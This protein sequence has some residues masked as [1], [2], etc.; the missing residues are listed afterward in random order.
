MKRILLFLFAFS[1]FSCSKEDL[2]SDFSE[3]S[4]DSKLKLSSIVNPGEIHNDYMDLVN[5]SFVA[6]ESI[7]TLDGKYNFYYDFIKE[8]TD[9]YAKIKSEDKLFF[10]ETFKENLNL[11]HYDN[12]VGIV[13]NEILI[14]NPVRETETTL[15]EVLITLRD[16]EIISENEFVKM[17]NLQYTLHKVYESTVSYD[18]FNV[19]IESL[20]EDVNNNEYLIL[21][22]VSSIASYSNEWWN[23]NLPEIYFPEPVGIINYPDNQY[24]TY[25]IPAVV[26]TDIAGAIVGA[27]GVALNQYINNNGKITGGAVVTGAVVGAV[28]GSTGLVGR[29]GKWISRL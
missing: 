23:S 20:S 16:E 1:I 15:S 13:K 25:A 4:D 24:T 28:V 8:Y 5:N 22:P 29:L 26:A 18:E 2:S 12:V 11:I 6:N 10:L 7:T 21:T 9:S 17:T 19:Y 27:A 14:S 3:N